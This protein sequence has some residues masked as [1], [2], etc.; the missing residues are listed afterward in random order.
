[1]LRFEQICFLAV[2]NEKNNLNF[3]TRLKSIK[4]FDLGNNIACRDHKKCD[5]KSG[6][7]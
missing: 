7:I 5:H 6:L 3:K 2:I 4:I 1:M